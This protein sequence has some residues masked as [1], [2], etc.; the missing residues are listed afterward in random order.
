MLGVE[1]LL[2]PQRRHV[3][4]RQL[5]G[6][7]R[8]V[9]LPLHVGELPQPRQQSRVRPLPQGRGAVLF[10][11]DEQGQTHLAL[12]FFLLPHRQKRLFPVPLRGAEA[13]GRTPVT[14]GL[15]VGQ[16]HC[17]PQV[18]QG[19]VEVP[20]PVMGHGIGHGLPERGADFGI[21]H[22]A[23]VAGEPRRHPQHVAVHGGHGLS[24]GDGQDG[25]R[26]VVPDACQTP[27]VV[28]TV[29]EFAAEILHHGLRRS[30]QIAGTAVI[31]QPLP[32]PHQLLLRH[33]GQRRHIRRGI[34]KPLKIGQ[35]RLDA[36]LLE[37]DLRHPRAV[38]GHLLPPGQHPPVG[39]VPRQQRGR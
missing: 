6:G 26:R 30:F 2:P 37:H 39:V 27:Q 5:R 1:D 7:G 32:Q 21:Q 11:H 29:R 12:L 10:L 36:G 38:G 19:L 9:Q 15:S 8:L 14:Q 33:G 28:I 31:A 20:G 3:P 16:A 18:H 23:A 24:E 4:L 35:Y 17:R 13:C 22:V 34:H 25:P